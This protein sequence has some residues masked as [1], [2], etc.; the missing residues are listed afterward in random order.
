[1]P[2]LRPSLI[3][4][5]LAAVPAPSIAKGPVRAPITLTYLGNAGW[6]IE[7]GHTVIIVDPYVSQFH[8]KRMGNPNTSDDSDDVLVPDEAQITAHIPR[9]DFL[10]GRRLP[11]A[12]I[13]GCGGGYE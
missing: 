8:D 3:L 11:K 5:M 6:Q 9:A 10:L 13:R 7:D 1:M 4:A 12:Q 2:G